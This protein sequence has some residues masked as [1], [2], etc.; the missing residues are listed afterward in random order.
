MKKR[1]LVE[2]RATVIRHRYEA[3]LAVAAR[4]MATCATSAVEWDTFRNRQR[5]TYTLNSALANA[6]KNPPRL[7]ITA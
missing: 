7:G 4:A 6:S 1:W 2:T 5:V 3:G